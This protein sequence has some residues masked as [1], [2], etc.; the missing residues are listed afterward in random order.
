MNKLYRDIGVAR[1]VREHFEKKKETETDP[2]L[3][4]VYE[5][6]I[7][8]SHEREKIALREIDRRL[9]MPTKKK[10]KKS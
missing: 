2:H 1:S 10:Q 9:D 8:M 4:R 5:N 6:F 3:L 7:T